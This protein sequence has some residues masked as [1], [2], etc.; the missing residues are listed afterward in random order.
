MRFGLCEG[1]LSAGVIGTDRLQFDVFG[2]T[3]KQ[4][5]ILQPDRKAQVNYSLPSVTTARKSDSQIQ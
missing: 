3:G 2:D 5:G 4:L 1:P